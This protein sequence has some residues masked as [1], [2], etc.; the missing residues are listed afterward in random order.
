[1]VTIGSTLAGYRIEGVAG[2]GG[3]GVV[4]RARQLRPDRL[5][6]LKVLATELLD[7]PQFRER[8]E[9]ESSIAASIEHPHVVP[10]YEVGEAEGVLFIAM[11]YVVG[12]DLRTLI[13]RGL[14]PDRSARIVDQTARALDAAHARGLVHRDVKP[15]N[16]LVGEADDEPH[17]FLTD[18]GLTKHLAMSRGPTRPGA[19]VGTI[20]YA[21]PEQVRGEKIDARADVYSLACM[22]Y[23]CLTGRV[24]YPYEADA[25]KLWAHVNQP[26][27]SLGATG[28]PQPWE[29][30]IGRGMAKEA[31][32]R[33]PS[34]GDLGRAVLAAVAA[35]PSSA[36]ERMVATGRAAPETAT[37]ASVPMTSTVFPAD[38]ERTPPTPSVTARSYGLKVAGRQLAIFAV[39][40]FALLA[41]AGLALVVGDGRRVRPAPERRKARRRPDPSGKDPDRPR[42][43]R[44]G[45]L[46]G[47]PE[48]RVG[49]EDRSRITRI[50][51]K[52]DPRGTRAL[53]RGGR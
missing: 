2:R 32:D 5:V 33:Y 27:P 7:D 6:A 13:R 18:F 3:M 31:A 17:A 25:A 52:A 22:L 38:G 19:L 10:V 23:E 41:A 45:D 43:R 11:R 24:P 14:S 30:I 53:R 4:Y 15:A 39:A 40:T 44:G 36:R 26:P 50:G 47:P 49:L 12:P 37:G 8:F 48:G 9:R 51:R 35:E 29:E 1:M 34:A 28:M 20:D 46:G 42:R 16:V 21:A